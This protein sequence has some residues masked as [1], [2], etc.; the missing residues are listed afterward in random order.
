MGA[1][2]VYGFPFPATSDA[3]NGPLQIEDVAQAIEDKIINI[4]AATVDLRELLQGYAQPVLTASG[5][6]A[7]NTSVVA[8][9][10]VIPDPGFP[11]RIVASGAYGWGMTTGLQ[12]RVISLHLN[13]DS[14]T[15]TTN[16]FSRGYGKAIADSIGGATQPT[17]ICPRRTTWT[18]T[19]YTGSHTVRLHV[20]NNA[21]AGDAAGAM[22]LNS[23]SGE[24]NMEVGVVPA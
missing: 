1:T 19:P 12:S 14:T 24:A 8:C 22:V 11:Y 3:P 6:L 2:A 4:D 15:R 23:T 7:A 18:F 10:L 17:V 21:A 20:F 16:E 9:T 13:V 5:A